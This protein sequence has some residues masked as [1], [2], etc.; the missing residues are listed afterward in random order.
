MTFSP[1]PPLRI[2][3]IEDDGG[4]ARLVRDLL[5]EREIGGLFPKVDLVSVDRLSAGRSRLAQRDISL[6]LLDLTLPDSQG[7]ATV[8]ALATEFPEV[9][10]IVLTGI[11]D[12]AFALRALQTGAQD[13]LIKS[14]VDRR[15][16]LKSMRYSL[17]RHRL[18]EQLRNLS[19]TDPLTGLYNRRGFLTFA[20]RQLKIARRRTHGAVVV[21]LDVD[22]LKTI[23]DH[24]GH[25]EG[26][27]ALERIASALRASFREEDIVGRLGGDE[28]AVVALDV[29]VGA[30]EALLERLRSQLD[31]ANTNPDQHYLL[32]LSTGWAQAE[33]DGAVTLEA[34]L[35]EADER[36][37]AEK[38]V[39]DS[40]SILKDPSDGG[41]PGDVAFR[42]GGHAQNGPIVRS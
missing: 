26:D 16:L 8:I 13:Y 2:L 10:L 9:P 32:R 4:Y 28:F 35:A 37:Y 36:L 22:G 19:L 40:T 6:V 27:R 33:S 25:A 14:E 24:Y 38:A 41:G 29:A 1:V 5:D 17:E 42:S 3:L 39:R 34:L 31:A 15:S 21:L 7:L 30:M 23:N 12:E 20:E 11:A 18:Q